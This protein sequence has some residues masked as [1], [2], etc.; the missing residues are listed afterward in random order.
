MDFEFSPKMLA[1]LFLVGGFVIVFM[2]MGLRYFRI[3]AFPASSIAIS[4][5]LHK[6]V[7]TSGS[8]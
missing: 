6:K 1:V 3:N 4:H 2:L 5:Q 7:Y 8:C